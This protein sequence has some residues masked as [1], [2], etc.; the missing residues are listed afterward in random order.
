MSATAHTIAERERRGVGVSTLER[1][2]HSGEAPVITA[3]VQRIEDWPLRQLHRRGALA[4][5]DRAENDRLHDIGE[6]LYLHASRSGLI[7]AMSPRT[8]GFERRSPSSGGDWDS[9]DV[10]HH[11]QVYA[12][13]I[14]AIAGKVQQVVRLMIIDEV[15][16]AETG[17]RVFGRENRGQAAAAA[18]E[19]LRHGLDEIGRQWGM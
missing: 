8:P 3:D 9:D 7:A 19:F 16:A 1:V 17:M 15:P 14:T 2:R 6:R 10:I 13:A 12:T 5:G 4:P 18:I 11:R